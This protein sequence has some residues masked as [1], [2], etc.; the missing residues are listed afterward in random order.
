M[1]RR[2]F[3]HD[4]DVLVLDPFAGPKDPGHVKATITV[5][6]YDMTEREIDELCDHRYG[7]GSPCVWAG[8]DDISPA[9]TN[10]VIRRAEGHLR[11]NK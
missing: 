11:G 4:I 9:H 1:N 5:N 2:D 3:Q 7:I 10:R 8:L 6:P